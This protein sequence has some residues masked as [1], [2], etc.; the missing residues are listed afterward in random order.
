MM[1]QYNN[2]PLGV[3]LN[4]TSVSVRATRFSASSRRRLNILKNIDNIDNI[5]NI[6]LSI[7]APL[8]IQQTGLPNAQL[9]D[10]ANLSPTSRRRLN[11]ASLAE[12]VLTVLLRN[13]DPIDYLVPP[14]AQSEVNCEIPV[15]EALDVASGTYAPAPRTI[16]GTCSTGYQFSITCPGVRGNFNNTCPSYEKVPLCTSYDNTGYFTPD[17]DC[18]V[19]KFD[20]N[21]TTC[22]CGAVPVSN[23][24]TSS[25]STS[26]RGL[27]EL[28]SSR[29]YGHGWGGDNDN[30]NS[31]T[32][33][34]DY[35]SFTP[36]HRALASNGFT[37]EV[38]STY[39]I[40]TSPFIQ[41]WTPA[42]DLELV[43]QNEVIMS[44]TATL[45]VVF[46]LGLILF[47]AWDYREQSWYKSQLNKK[48]LIK[49][50][51]E[52]YADEDDKDEDDNNNNNNNN[53]DIADDI[54][55]ILSKPGFSSKKKRTIDAFFENVIPEEFNDGKWYE[56]LWK[57][58]L[59]E[60]TWLC[61]FAPHRP[62][63]QLRVIKFAISM[64]NLIAF[65]VTTTV[66]A[67]LFFKDDGTC[68]HI[69]A[70]DSCNASSSYLGLRSICSFNNSNDY[71]MFITPIADFLTVLYY[72]MSAATLAVRD[73][74]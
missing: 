24:N 58:L 68:E 19:T 16:L 65:L 11:V 36:G 1:L 20:S 15:E 3:T 42:P 54:S 27:L 26:R 4:A 53:K 31:M 30:S 45:V 38:S 2:N 29:R 50:K 72:T 51:S 23:F 5:D 67:V 61:L 66:L 9:L 32:T 69:S 71:C 55:D 43:K 37:L 25:N 18:T 73:V 7:G 64:T 49:K 34:G 41:R 33:E 8:L 40:V 70:S 35:S 59:L 74:I 21:I 28:G 56:L 14:V 57:R 13:I 46:V 47:S 6:E 39:K 62:D 52:L 17:S 12:L 63:R 44:T 10:T 60:H 48:P 22:Q